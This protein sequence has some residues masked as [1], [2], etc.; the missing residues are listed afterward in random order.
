MNDKS[1]PNAKVIPLKSVQGN[2]PLCK[3]PTAVEFRPFCSKRC[4]DKDLG[5]WLNESY[6]FETDET[7]ESL[8]DEQ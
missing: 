4:A 6:K 5:S 8:E 7:T 3:R 1:K 2:C